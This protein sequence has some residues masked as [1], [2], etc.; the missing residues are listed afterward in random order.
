MMTAMASTPCHGYNSSAEISLLEDNS[1]HKALPQLSSAIDVNLTDTA[2]IAASGHYRDPSIAKLVSHKKSQTMFCR[3]TSLEQAEAEKD[4]AEEHI[5]PSGS[6]GFQ[7][8]K[9]NYSSKILDV[10]NICFN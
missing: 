4:C 6:I 2:F 8:S 5:D 7:S 10:I 1:L 9:G 3:S